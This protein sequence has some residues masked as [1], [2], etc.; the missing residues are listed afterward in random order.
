MC[1]PQR[2]VIDMQY[3]LS[4][5]PAFRRL[6]G[7]RCRWLIAIGVMI[8]LGGCVTGT[9]TSTRTSSGKAMQIIRSAADATLYMDTLEYELNEAL[10]DSGITLERSRDDIILRMPGAAAFE[11]DKAEIKPAFRKL[12]APAAQVLG[13][14]DRTLIGVSGYTDSSGSMIRNMELSLERAE[15]VAALLTALGIAAE[16][17]APQGLGPLQPLADNDSADGRQLNR[18]VELTI[19]PLMHLP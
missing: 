10:A 7:G 19:R 8:L 18:R 6:S 3:T 1:D 13:S 15:A 12:L 17:I 11:P 16:R 5:L 4:P 2:N 9:A 14:F